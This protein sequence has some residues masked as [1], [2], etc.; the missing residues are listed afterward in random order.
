MTSENRNCQ[1][2]KND[3]TIESEDF[4]F[5]EKIKVPPPTWCPECRAM[6]RLAWRNERS[7]YHNTCAFSGKPI[8][9]M[10]SPEMGL[11]VYDRDIWW[12]DKWNPLDYGQDYDF[13]K[14]FFEQYK[15]LLHRVPLL[16]LGNTNC[17]KSEYGNHNENLRNSYLVYASYTGEN[18]YYS[19]GLVDVKDS[20]DLYKLTKSEQCYNSTLCASCY[21][22]HF[23]YDSDECINCTFVTSCLGLH[24]CLGCVN[25]RHKRNCIFNKQY[26]PEEYAKKL[27]EYDLGSYNGLKK[28]EEEY[29]EFLKT[30]FRRY[31]FLL[32]SVN[33]TGD[34]I[35]FAKNSRMVF[36]SYGEME[37]CKYITHAVTVKDS[38]DAYGTG[39]KMELLYEGVDAG[40][41]AY[42]MHFCIL[43][44][45]CVNVDYV[46]TC[47]NIAY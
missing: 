10:F 4:N 23:S 17:V 24:D 34:N 13:S 35:M 25:L 43:A 20:W 44:H 38:Y 7:L 36:D 30:Q 16:N 6:R 15:E 47:L 46:Y 37:N 45:S 12:S 39:A 42:N 3:F 19:N 5:Y 18:V 40:I 41:N 9:S 31:A 28:F 33:S 27:K 29:K 22:T 2:C 14:P 1:N 21:N 32:K 11:T 8:I 26:T